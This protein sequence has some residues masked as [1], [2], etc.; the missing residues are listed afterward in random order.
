[1]L[2]TVLMTVLFSGMF[3]NSYV[4]VS[5]LFTVLESNCCLHCYFAAAFFSGRDVS[6]GVCVE[7]SLLSVTG[8]QYHSS[9]FF[10]RFCRMNVRIMYC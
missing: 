5:V 1:M 6:S 8:I 9:C 2:L 3:N 7:V 10:S 4:S